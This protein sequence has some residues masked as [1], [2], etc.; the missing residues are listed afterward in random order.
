MVSNQGD[1]MKQPAGLCQTCKLFGSF[2]C[3][4]YQEEQIPS[5]ILRC[6]NYSDKEYDALNNSTQRVVV[7]N[8]SNID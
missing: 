2:A 3:P 8:P 4:L 7:E 5:E 1:T 6:A